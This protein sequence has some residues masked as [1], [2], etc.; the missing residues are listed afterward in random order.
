MEYIYRLSKESFAKCYM[1]KK[2]NIPNLEDNFFHRRL[3]YQVEY[4]RICGRHTDTQRSF[5]PCQSPLFKLII[6]RDN[7]LTMVN[8]LTLYFLPSQ[9]LTL[10]PLGLLVKRFERDRMGWREALSLPDIVCHQL[11]QK[12]KTRWNSDCCLP[13]PVARDFVQITNNISMRVVV[14][15]TFK[16]RVVLRIYFKVGVAFNNQ[17]NII[18]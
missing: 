11:C 3:A 8:N 4:I 13:S 9:S 14:V 7:Q 10:S 17:C 18:I 12:H 1:K 15:I 6:G 2:K 5:N 16:T